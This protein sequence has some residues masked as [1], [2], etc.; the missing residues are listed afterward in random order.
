[1][2]AMDEV[3]LRSLSVDAREATLNGDQERIR[4]IFELATSIAHGKDVTA[5]VRE[6]FL[7]CYGC[8]A[9]TDDVLT[10]LVDTLCQNVVGNVGVGGVGG[11]D[12]SEISNYRGFIEIGAG[13][14]QWARALTD[15]YKLR[16]HNSRDGMSPTPPPPLSSSSPSKFEFVKAYDSMKELPLNPTVYHPQTAPS[17]KHF[18]QNVRE[19]S[20]HIDIVRRIENRGRILLLVYPPP[21][22]MA[23]ETVKAYV[24]SSSSSSSSSS[25]ILSSQYTRELPSSLRNDT[26][27][28]VGEGRGGANADDTFFDYLEAGGWI[29]N[30]T[31]EVGTAPG[32]KGCEKLFVFKWIG[33]T[34]AIDSKGNERLIGI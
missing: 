13:N 11:F 33:N 5:E 19:C 17:S 34:V 31:M 1:M 25:S 3:K 22:S 24:D 6:A 23:V 10:Y 12:R 32:G 8:A 14:G 29:L 9:W 7:K 28:Y 18:Y 20:S 15:L 26:V 2:R 21:G 30:Q 4:V 27:V 16:L